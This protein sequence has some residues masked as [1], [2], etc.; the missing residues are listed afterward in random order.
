MIVILIT[1]I[2]R[3]IYKLCFHQAMC[4]TYSFS[5]K[6]IIK[7]IS[8]YVSSHDSKLPLNGIKQNRNLKARLKVNCSNIQK[9]TCLRYKS[10]K[11]KDTLERF[12]AALE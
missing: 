3:N 8:P 10:Y 6:T 1:L 4:V 12:L 11:L 7:F 5:V 2:K 9:R